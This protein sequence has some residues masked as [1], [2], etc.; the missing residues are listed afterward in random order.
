MMG[1]NDIDNDDWIPLKC[2][3]KGGNDSDMYIK[4]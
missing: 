1:K 3:S 4:L 2:N